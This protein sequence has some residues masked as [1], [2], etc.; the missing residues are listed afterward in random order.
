M[1]PLQILPSGTSQLMSIVE[2][3]NGQIQEK[4]VFLLFCLCVCVCVRACLHMYVLILCLIV[5]A[6]FIYLILRIMDE[7]EP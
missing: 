5:E 2:D 6:D 1:W 7:E 4:C 3:N